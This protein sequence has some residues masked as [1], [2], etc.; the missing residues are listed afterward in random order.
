MNNKLRRL[1][2]EPT[3]ICN[4]ACVGCPTNNLLRG[5]GSMDVKLYKAIFDEVGNDLER[6]FLWG[7]GEPLLHP[8]ISD[9]LRHSRNFSTRKIMST[10]GWKFEDL[11]D[12][13][14]LAYLDE[15]IVSI[16][17]LTP[18]TY[19]I[20][21]VNGDLEKVIRGLKKVSPIIRN[22]KTRFIMQ[23]VAHKGNLNELE[24]AEDFARRYGFDM[25]V[26]KSFNVMDGKQETFDRFV[27]LGTPYSRYKESLKDPPR[28][29]ENGVYP[30]EEGMVINWD[31]SVNPCCWDYR[32]QYNFGN[33]KERGVY[34]VWNSMAASMHRNN[35]RQGKFLGICVNCANSKIIQIKS[36]TSKGGEDVKKSI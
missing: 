28:K 2:I 8:Q 25:L 34:S 15:L 1:N 13:E 33:V 12:P 26:I 18:E 3:S 6:V 14:S 23:M 27:P 19:A 32:G 29:P 30:C 4:Y 35:I 21:Q 31:G 11:S 10:T 16:N 24:K 20:H 9:M 22:S 7:Y 17:G 5:K 36:F